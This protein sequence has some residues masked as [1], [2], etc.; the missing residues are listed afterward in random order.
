VDSDDA[1]VHHLGRGRR[2]ALGTSLPFRHRNF[3]LQVRDAR[4]LEVRLR[5]APPLPDTAHVLPRR[6]DAAHRRRDRAAYEAVQPVVVGPRRPERP[7]VDD[8]ALALGLDP[9]FG[10]GHVLGE[11]FVVPGFLAEERDGARI[12]RRRRKTPCT[13]VFQ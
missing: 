4:T 9:G 12:A 10:V 8:A 11:E 13:K 6:L 7:F 3:C 1:G 2:R 5:V